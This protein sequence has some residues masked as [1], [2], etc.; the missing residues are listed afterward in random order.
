MTTGWPKKP[1]PWPK[2]PVDDG[3]ECPKCKMKWKGVMGYVCP[4][5]KCPIQPKATF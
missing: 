1:E 4:D 5:N 2:I 3:I